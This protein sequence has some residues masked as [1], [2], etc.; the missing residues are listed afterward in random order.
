MTSR[1]VRL[2]ATAVLLGM[3]L[4]QALQ[5]QMKFGTVDM[6]KV[7]DAYYKTKQ[8]EVQIKERFAD[9]EKVYKGM[10]EDYQRAN[11]EYRKLVESSNDQA[12]S[13]V[14]RERRKQ[15]AETKLMEIQE[16]EKSMKQFQAQSRETLGAL[17]K[18][19]R[20]N[21]VKEI[22][23]LLNTK[24]QAGSYTMIFD[25]AAKTMYQTPFILYHSGV[26]DLTDE[27]IRDLNANAPAGAVTGEAGATLPGTN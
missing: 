25:T 18:R 17:E 1:F 26:S 8:A 11:D 14:E 4:P 16:I 22:R 19:M 5:A 2:A 9:S 27:L 20:D 7:F 10:V 12:I 6:T 21:I 24:A 15:S 13:E 3:I 23:D